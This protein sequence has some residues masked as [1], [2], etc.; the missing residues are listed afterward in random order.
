MA[1]QYK[2]CWHD[3]VVYKFKLTWPPGSVDVLNHE[4]DLITTILTAVS[5]DEYP[6]NLSNH[7]F[8][9][10]IEYRKWNY[11]GELVF[12]KDGTM[13]ELYRYHFY[14]RV[15]K[16]N[17]VARSANVSRRRHYDEGDSSSDEAPLVPVKQKWSSR[18]EKRKIRLPAMYHYRGTPASHAVARRQYRRDLERALPF[19]VQDCLRYVKPKD[20]RQD[21]VVRQY[22][23][24]DMIYRTL[25]Y[26]AH[27]PEAQN[28][29]SAIVFLNNDVSFEV[30]EPRAIQFGQSSEPAPSTGLF[31]SLK[32]GVVTVFSKMS[33]WIV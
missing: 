25:Q 32:R 23:V 27:I 20:A 13:Y 22:F 10:D 19:S 29:D 2:L 24:P 9:A 18:R 33:K 5:E 16:N 4:R 8:T 7:E 26:Y 28:D 3:Q 30:R 6:P 1:A 21:L 14:V 12:E 11:S 15:R 17:I 31:Q